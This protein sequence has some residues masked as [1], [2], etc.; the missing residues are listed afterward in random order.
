M[1][2]RN[3]H[4]PCSGCNV[5]QPGPWQPEGPIGSGPCSP[6]CP[7]PFPTTAENLAARLAQETLPCS[8]RTCAGGYCGCP[9]NVRETRS[10]LFRAALSALGA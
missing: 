8:P 6:C 7:G 10:H 9:D 4:W 1:S 2:T 3:W 5:I